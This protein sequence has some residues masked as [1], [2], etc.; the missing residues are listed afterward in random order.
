[1]MPALSEATFPGLNGKLVF[2]STSS[3]RNDVF[4]KEP[5]RDA[6]D[7]N[8]SNTPR[9]DEIT[10]NWSPDGTK[11]AFASNRDD[12]G[13]EHT[14]GTLET[15][16][17]NYEI[18]VMNAYGT[19]QT[20][21]TFNGV[22][23][24]NPNWSR[25]GSRLAFERRN[26]TPGSGPS[27][28]YIISSSGEGATNCTNNSADDHDPVWSPTEDKIA[29]SSNRTGV[30]EDIWVT[31]V[32]GAVCSSASNLT[33]HPYSAFNRGPDW[34]PDGQK[35]AFYSD[36][37]PDP[38]IQGGRNEDVW[39]MNK[40]GTDQT[41]VTKYPGYP[42]NAACVPGENNCA[43]R[44]PAWSPDGKMIAFDTSRNWP[45][46]TFYI[47]QIWLMNVGGSN[48]TQ[49]S[50]ARD[51]GPDWQP[52]FAPVASFELSPGSVPTGQLVSFDGS[53]STNR[54]GGALDY[55]W[56]LDGDGA[57][58]TSTGA[59][60]TASRSYPRAAR[61]DV[62]LMVTNFDGK[63]TVTS[64]SLTISNRPPTGFIATSPNPA[65]TGQPVTFD[66]SASSDP[67]GAI[68]NY[69]WDLDGDGSFETNTGARP[70]ATR[71]Y[72]RAAR[73]AVKLRVTDNDGS[74]NEGVGTSSTKMLVV[75]ARVIASQALFSFLTTRG[76]LRIRNLLVRDVPPGARVELTCKK[77]KRE[78][79][80]RQ[81]RK[82]TT[83]SPRAQLPRT[84]SFKPL[85][86]KRLSIGTLVEIR[87]TKQNYVGKYIAYRIRSGGF[88]KRERCMEPGS[89]TPKRRCS[90]GEERG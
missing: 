37:D 23:D 48:Q 34:S 76:G 61:I 81:S 17:C 28:I 88:R 77:G 51:A 8:R 35:I 41:N 1:M 25:D 26:G 78:A 66:A 63:T 2:Q 83:A 27:E 42:Q 16:E 4:V 38:N 89:K 46:G 31:S 68:T 70:T 85:F 87:V 69:R 5:S 40:D 75:N 24:R 44:S 82:S 7:L 58:E 49:L 33:D 3:G 18:Y 72:S 80:K 86:G 56:D 47:T 90:G 79:C 65:L 74:T 84:I 29:F 54:V 52:T 64:R 73:I 21:L 55:K 20:R 45:P 19:N 13:L 59:N 14:C 12:P 53:G 9:A 11:I 22:D 60:P 43:D 62:G 39:V 10:P 71:S 67:D 50:D 30:S 36:R 15:P 32:N 6:P 57:F